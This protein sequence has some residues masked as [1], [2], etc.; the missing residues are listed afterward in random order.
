MPPS[1]KTTPFRSEMRT[2]K[3]REG[4]NYLVI[5]FWDDHNN[6]YEYHVYAEVIAKQAARDVAERLGIVLPPSDENNV[7]QYWDQIWEEAMQ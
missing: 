7:R 1:L 2:I 3:G 5:R 4:Y 6:N